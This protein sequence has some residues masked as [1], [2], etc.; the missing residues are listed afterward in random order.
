MTTPFETYSNLE[1]MAKQL[2]ADMTAAK[3]K[4][5]RNRLDSKLADIENQMGRMVNGNSELARLLGYK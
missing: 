1:Q 3:T 2:R 4:A 5:Q